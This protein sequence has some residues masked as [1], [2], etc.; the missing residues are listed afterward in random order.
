MKCGF[1]LSSIYSQSIFKYLF[2]CRPRNSSRTMY[3]GYLLV[4]AVAAS[5]N[6]PSSNVP[7]SP[8]PNWYASFNPQNKMEHIYRHFFFQNLFEDH[9]HDAVAIQAIS[10][11]FVPTFVLVQICMYFKNWILTTYLVM[12]T[13]TVLIHILNIAFMKMIE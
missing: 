9:I 3:T 8:L 10:V 4:G 7:V 12:W 6:G 5:H 2:Y 1:N 11:W 13:L